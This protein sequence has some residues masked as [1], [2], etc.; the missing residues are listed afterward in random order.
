MRYS[1]ALL[2]FSFFV[3]F[4]SCNKKEALQVNNYEMTLKKNGVSD[5]LTPY[6]CAIQAN[7]IT[8]S[9]T[10]FFLSARSKDNRVNFC[11]AIQVNGSFMPGIY[12]TINGSGNY[13]VIAD[14]FLDQGQP[15]ERDYTIDNAP[16]SPYGYFKVTITSIEGN[17]VKG[18]FSGNYLYD[19]SYNESIVVTE[20][21]FIAKTH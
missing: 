14:Y 9:K 13:P 3:F 20:G 6:Y 16:N 12:E 11:I 21:S 5:T 10:D 18:T 4:Y 19:R 17:V 8:P 1:L 7:A 15:S 2:L